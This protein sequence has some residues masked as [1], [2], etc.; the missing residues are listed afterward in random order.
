M[1]AATIFLAASLAGV[2]TSGS[3]LKAAPSPEKPA[4][5]SVWT[6]A[7]KTLTH[8]AQSVPGASVLSELSPGP[9]SQFRPTSATELQIPWPPSVAVNS[10]PTAKPLG[11]GEPR[12]PARV[13]ERPAPLL[14]QGAVGN[15]TDDK[16][17]AALPRKSIDERVYDV[18]FDALTDGAR[19][20][21]AGYPTATAY[22]FQGTLKGVQPM[23]D[24]R[25]QLQETIRK[26]LA[27]AQRIPSIDRRAW[28]LREILVDVRSSLA[29][30]P[31]MPL[32]GAGKGNTLWDRLG[33]E[34]NVKRIVSYFVDAGL[35]DPKVH[36]TRNG[37]Y[38]M[39]AEQVAAFKAKLV[40]L[41]GAA[42]GGTE[43]YSGKSMKESHRGMGITDAEFD[44]LLLHLKVALVRNGITNQKDIATIME[45][46]AVTRADIVEPVAVASAPE[47]MAAATTL[48]ERLG[49]EVNVRR[50]VNDF[51]DTALADPQV[52][53]TR[54]GKY[55]LTAEQIADQKNKLVTLASAIGG[56]P[57]KYEGKSMKE[58]HRGMAITDA[59]FDALLG[60]LRAA[61]SKHQVNKV[62]A[63]FILQAI[64][65]RRQDIVEGR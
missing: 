38:K 30:P 34:A 7:G 32:V 28:A 45:A 12:S 61:L 37:K 17:A 26:S 25:P 10:T 43:R 23:L 24:H 36:F 31:L 6:A 44:A 55:K 57:Y 40:Q 54:G 35:A 52:N 58:A 62:D 50:I 2:W 33:G 59:E 41:A 42:L 3:E 29:P 5:W 53:Y 16:P 64:G 11:H 8:L 13:P 63:F 51:I 4:W 39:S 9:P 49:G 21:N 18:L 14:V 22:L 27:E 60:H 65:S 20:Y 48:W 56:G 15:G 19:L 47:K 1:Q 46:V